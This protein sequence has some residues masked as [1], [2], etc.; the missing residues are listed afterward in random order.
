MLNSIVHPSLL[1]I[2]STSLTSAAWR[3]RARHSESSKVVKWNA[4]VYGPLTTEKKEFRL[5]RVHAGF[6][7]SPIVASL[8]AY[9]LDDAPEY[10]AL[11]YVWGEPK[12]V[13]LIYINGAKFFV[14]KHLEKGLQHLRRPDQDLVIWI[15]AICINQSSSPER[16]EQVAH[17]ETIYKSAHMVRVWLDVDIDGENPAVK[18]LASF[19]VANASA[20]D[21]G[22][23]PEFWLPL[24][25]YFNDGYWNRLWIQQE[26]F[27]ARRHVFHCRDVELDGHS[28]DSF[29]NVLMF[30]VSGV[31]ENVW[32]DLHIRFDL[33]SHTKMMGYLRDRER[34]PLIHNMI[35]TIVL[36]VTDPRDRVYGL[37]SISGD[38]SRLLRNGLEISYEK[39]VGAVYTDTV[40]ANIR[41]SGNLDHLMLAARHP[42]QSLDADA[43]RPSW[44]PDWDTMT[45]TPINGKPQERADGRV[46]LPNIVIQSI[47]VA[48]G[49]LKVLG[50][51]VATITHFYKS[52]EVSVRDETI[53]AAIQSIYAFCEQA[54]SQGATKTKDEI[55][56]HFVHTIIRSKYSTKVL[57]DFLSAEAS[58][59]EA[60]QDLIAGT[61]A[62][63][64]LNRTTKKG[65]DPGVFDAMDPLLWQVVY[66]L[67]L[68]V[69]TN[70]LA[71]TSGGHVVIMFKTFAAVGDHVWVIIGSE[72]PMV[73]RPVGGD[74]LRWEV[75]GA[76]FSAELAR[77]QALAQISGQESEYNWLGLGDEG[78]TV[79]AEKYKQVYFASK[80]IWLA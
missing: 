5:L 38:G 62:F 18:R 11:S 59:F 55:F 74:D 77:G 43:D 19:P 71:F 75:A 30:R 45:Q 29:L 35:M 34:V 48:P 49:Q 13:A 65:L 41:A 46:P 37:L 73:L 47:D 9:S 53:G 2:M 14:T 8:Q 79:P 39:S 22:D 56:R 50:V 52:P 1:P 33:F 54:S 17:M 67:S 27:L 66:G 78:L 6:R 40:L 51:P 10:D 42:P 23:E 57:P 32:S 64:N 7:G 3:F 80:E 15:D 44:V 21:L 28:V 72:V 25:G 69:R 26:L 63:S 20:D 4:S 36:K 12:F 58:I 60:L 70:D 68:V 16:G 76:C 31:A 61:S 24:E